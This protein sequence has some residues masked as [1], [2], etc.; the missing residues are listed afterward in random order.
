MNQDILSRLDAA[1]KAITVGNLG[2]GILAP[3]QF[4]RFVR[5]MQRRTNILQ[6]AR[7]MRMESQQVN[8]DRIGFAGYVLTQG[9]TAA[10]VNRGTETKVK[11][12]LAINKLQ[13]AEFRGAM[14]LEDRAL[15][16]NIERGGLEGTLVDLFGEAA[17]RDIET[18]GLLGDTDLGDTLLGTTNGWLE[19]AAHKLEAVSGAADDWPLNLFEAALQEMPKQFLTNPGEFRFYVPWLVADAYRNALIA[20]KYTLSDSV[21]TGGQVPPYKGIPVVVSGMLERSA[22]YDVAALLSHPDNMVW[23]VFHEVTI[24]PDRIAASRRTDFYLTVEMDV[25][26]EDEN[27]AVAVFIENLPTP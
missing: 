10:G 9:I 23:G 25:H 24:E 16:R 17:G 15:R 5:A 13:A 19:K 11:P 2:E 20:R 18:I 8:I 14:G 4:D 27:A 1:I 7:F 3:E 26:Y 12:A 6:E 22:V 21:L